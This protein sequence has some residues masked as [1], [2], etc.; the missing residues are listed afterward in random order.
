M[1]KLKIN[2]KELEDAIREIAYLNPLGIDIRTLKKELERRNLKASP[3]IIRR[4]LLKLV[5]DKKISIQHGKAHN[6]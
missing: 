3:Q 4:N 5:K 1:R 6:N 2:E